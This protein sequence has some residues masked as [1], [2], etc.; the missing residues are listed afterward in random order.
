MKMSFSTLGCRDW[1]LDQII[2]RAAEYGFD[3]IGFRGLNGELDLTKVDEFSPSRRKHTLALLKRAGLVCNMVLTST[4]VMLTDPAE[5]AASLQNA[6]DHIDL[7]ADLESSAVRIFGGAMLSGLSHATAVTR[8]G[9]RLRELGRHAEG[10]GVKVLFET[11]DDWVRPDLVRRVIEHADHPDVRVLWDVHHPYRIAE[12]PI[13]EVWNTL[14][15]WI[16]SVDIKDSRLDPSARLGYRYVKLGEGDI[17]IF[18]ALTLLAGSGYQ[19]WLNFEWEKRWHPDIEEPEV[20]FPHF[21]STMTKLL[22]AI[23]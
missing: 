5:L 13:A 20:S 2:G 19:G 22:A 14:G 3:G 10:K 12:I 18:E 6:R 8:A 17:P 21:R 11:H 4:R 16:E 15:R 9:D 23:R 7:A 1:T